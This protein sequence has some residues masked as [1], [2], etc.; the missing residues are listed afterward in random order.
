MDF[1]GTCSFLDFVDSITLKVMK[2]KYKMEKNKFK[3]K[4]FYY[5]K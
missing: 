2:V 4:I 1:R 3:N 5:C